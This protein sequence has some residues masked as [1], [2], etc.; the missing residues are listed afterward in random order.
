MHKNL[1]SKIKSR[2]FSGNDWC[3]GQGFSICC[4]VF[5]VSA[6]NVM[7]ACEQ[8]ELPRA[9]RN[10]MA[11]LLNAANSTTSRLFAVITGLVPVI[12]V[13]QWI[14][15]VNKFALL[16]HK[17]RFRQ[18]C[19]N[20][21]GNDGCWGRLFM[22]FQSLNLN[23]MYHPG[24]SANE[25][26]LKAKDDYRSVLQSGR[27]MIEMLG[28]LAIIA[29]LSVGGI[30]GYSKA[31]N[32]Y[33]VN[34]VVEELNLILFRAKEL[35]QKDHTIHIQSLNPIQKQALG[36]C[37]D[38]CWAYWKT[39]VG[40][41]DVYS[42]GVTVYRTNP[43]LCIAVINNVA[44]P[45]RNIVKYARIHLRASQSP[46]DIA[47]AWGKC[48]DEYDNKIK[49]CEAMDKLE[50]AKC[51]REAADNKEDC[52]NYADGSSNLIIF[53]NYNAESKWNAKYQRGFLDMDDERV[54]SA[55]NTVC[56]NSNGEK[57]VDIRFLPGV[58][59][60]D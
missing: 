25:L 41:I 44:K 43:D 19:R 49:E 23:R 22:F 60:N 40:W 18:D 3:C 32:T 20:T 16:L 12:L 58:T 13:Q 30:A 38:Y 57:V 5:N 10:I 4:S 50:K 15:L 45:L 39:S 28:V 33:K 31:M 2:L 27:S 34:K 52:Q 59:G 47:N 9:S 37:P 55:V 14:N 6:L 29:V 53:P 51:R 24:S 26:P 7:L 21:S 11:I 48:R 54:L 35:Y 42:G 56:H 36:L 17:Y 46:E 8:S 1:E